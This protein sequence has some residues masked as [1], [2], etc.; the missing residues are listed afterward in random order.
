[1]HVMLLIYPGEVTC[2]IICIGVI[3]NTRARK[4]ERERERSLLT[5]IDD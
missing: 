2:G 4:R 5:F 1:M 3:I